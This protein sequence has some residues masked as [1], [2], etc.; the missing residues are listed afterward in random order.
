METRSVEI[1]SAEPAE[2]PLGGI[3]W[4]AV[5]AGLAVG[6][7]IQLLLML[8][9]IATGL[10]VYGA[11]ERPDGSSLT[12]AAGIWNTISMIL[13]ALVGGYVAARSSGLRRHADGIIHGVV[14]W[15][16]S[17]LFFAL[18][19]GSITGSAISGMFGVAGSPAVAARSGDAASSIGPLLSSIERG[20]RQRTISIMRDRFALNEEQATQAADRALALGGRPESS[21]KP[22]TVNDAAQTASAASTWLSLMILL[23]LLAGAGGGLFGARGARQ[24]AYHG[25]YD[26]QRVL[27]RAQATQ[28]VPLTR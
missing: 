27:H 22:E 13:A 5:F 8:F 17:M 4:P 11:G 21:S 15:G 19:T 14:S 1:S 23:S 20:D 25:R 10:A 24:R 2:I 3:R 26:E 18:L 16:A 7:G 12:I 6:L 9:G 28:H